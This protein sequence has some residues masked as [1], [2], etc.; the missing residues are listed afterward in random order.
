MQTVLLLG[1]YGFLGT[2][3][4]KYVDACDLPYRFITFDR[5]SRHPAGV[6]FRCIVASYAGDFTDPIALEQ[7][8]KEHTIDL[9]IHSLSTTVPLA[10]G[11]PRYDVETNLLPTITLMDCMV[12]HHV[13]RLVFFSSGGAVYG[14]VHTNTPHK[15]TDEL[16]P[17]SSYGVVKLAIEKYMFL[18][19]SLFGLQPMVLRLSNP[20]GQWHYSQRQGIINIALRAAKEGKTFTVWGDGSTTK[21]Y[22][23]APDMCALL[24]RLL[25]K[26]AYGEV[27]NVASGELLSVNDILQQ[28]KQLYPAFAWT[29]QPAN[30]HDIPRVALDTA[31]LHQILGEPVS[32]HTL[33]ET[34]RT[35]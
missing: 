15:E 20:Y 1:A 13:S 11:S 32:M 9:V 30:A 17:K 16:Y 2:N 22:I 10:V 34:I 3:V 18:Y 14:D 31:R 21:D 5:T 12:R 19:R 27:I 33:T 28:I 23:Y 24:F 7:P 4:M 29:Y 26:E 8:F 25:E 35:L 6:T